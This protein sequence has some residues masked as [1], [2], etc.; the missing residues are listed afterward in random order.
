VLDLASTPTKILP[1]IARDNALSG[2]VETKQRLYQHHR[3][4]T[5]Y[6]MFWAR[7]KKEII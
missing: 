2:N 7:G 1:H 6:D 5:N 3:N 4:I